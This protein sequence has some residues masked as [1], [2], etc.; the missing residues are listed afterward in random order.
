MVTLKDLKALQD[1]DGMTIKNGKPIQYKTGFQV[2]DHG[3]T[4]KNASTA[5]KAILAMNGNCGV[6][7]D[8]GTYYIDHSFRI[9]G[10]RKAIETGRKFNQLSIYDWKRGVCINC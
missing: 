4:T 10:K 1:G 6:W 2:A 9:S 3:I 5:Y 7:L 8:N